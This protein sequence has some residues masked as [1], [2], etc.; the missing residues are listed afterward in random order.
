MA[1]GV[2]MTERDVCGVVSAEARATNCNAMAI[3]LAAREV[4]HVANDHIFVR[5]VSPHSIGRVNRFI[6]QTFQIDCVRAVNGDFAVVD[7]PCHGADQ[8][9]ILIFA[10]TGTRRWKQNQRHPPPFPKAS[11]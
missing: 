4:E 7:V 1:D 11:I 5:V 2:R 9:E 8:P 10:I 3:A 6:V